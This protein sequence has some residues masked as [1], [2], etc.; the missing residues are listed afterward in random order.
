MSSGHAYPREPRT[1]LQRA[2]LHDVSTA[3]EAD[4][5]ALL[6]RHA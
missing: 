4:S 2:Q 1:R 5:D 6:E 3:L